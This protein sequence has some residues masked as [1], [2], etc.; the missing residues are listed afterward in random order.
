MTTSERL[1]FLLAHP[2]LML[3]YF[4]KVVFFSDLHMGDA[5][6]ADDFKTNEK[7]FCKIFEYY[8]RENFIPFL[9]GDTEELW[10]FN[11]KEVINI[12][13]E[14]YFGDCHLIKGNHDAELNLP[15]A[16]LLIN[17]KPILLIHGHQGDW[18][19]DKYWKI[20]RWFA[21]YPWKILEYIGFQ[22][23]W[24]S[25]SKNMKRHELVRMNL[26]NWAN[27]KKITLVCG[28]VHSQE[29]YGYYWNV[30]SGVIPGRIECI[31]FVD[32][33]LMLKVWK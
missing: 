26:M 9:L 11:R 30:G 31:E 17:D 24:F 32:G 25:P 1:D 22:D 15:E 29:H 2:P 27:D 8:L 4:P 10:Q 20:G 13:G 28:H 5:G 33:I 7:L 3:P 16:I 23:N 12:Y 19:N 21:R 18:I 6:P 14:A